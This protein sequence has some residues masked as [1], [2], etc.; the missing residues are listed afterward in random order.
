MKLAFFTP[1]YPG[2]TQEGGI[3]SYTRSL[4]MML[5]RL[6]H[7]VHVVTPGTGDITIDAGV[8][9]HQ[10]HLRHVPIVDRLLPG[11][12][13]CYHLNRKM[14]QLVKQHQIDLVEFP[15][16]E[17]LGIYYQ[18]QHITAT[19][20]RLHTSS[21][22]T[23]LIDDLPSTRLLRSDVAREH[24]QARQADLLITHSMAHRK[25][26]SDELGI[27][28]ERIKL[29]PHGV[30]VYPDFVRPSRQPGPPRIVFLGRLEKR[31]GTLELLQ[32]F[33]QVLEQHPGT[34]LTLIG[35]DRA[36][37]PALPG[38]SPRTHQQWIAD[39]L[40]PPVKQQVHLTGRL[41][42]AEVDRH[43]QT[44][45]VFIAPSRYESFGL[46]YP[47]AM[48]WGIPV[49]GCN[50]GGVPEIIQDGVT[51]LL[52]P[53]ESPEAI[54]SVLNSLLADESL[55]HRLGQAGRHHVEKHFSVESMA[56]NVIANFERLLAANARK[57]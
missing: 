42:P 52:I 8:H 33:P 24:R 45:D 4:A 11:F 5:S 26:M 23:Q 47:E 20:V 43:L 35:S 44:A 48:R 55:R 51:G 41:P 10:V 12:G 30:E 22:E 53:P 32:A 3:G 50:V 54:A 40:P 15:N 25:L 38:G 18:A 14:I 1:N 49:I 9:V 31:K 21:K 17:G 27:A 56:Q 34:E 37:C 2:I 36:H 28:E 7:T 57:N 39:E 6:G 46:I 16:W 19:A 13:N 29:I